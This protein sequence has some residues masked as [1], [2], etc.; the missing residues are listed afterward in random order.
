MPDTIFATSQKSPEREKQK[1]SRTKLID[2]ES[3]FSARALQ[4]LVKD[5]SDLVVDFD[6]RDN[7]PRKKLCT[8]EDLRMSIMT[9]SVFIDSRSLEKWSLMATSLLLPSR[10]LKTAALSEE[11]M[12]QTILQKFP[13]SS[14]FLDEGLIEDGGFGGDDSFY[15]AENSSVGNFGEK[16]TAKEISATTDEILNDIHVRTRMKS[17][18]TFDELLGSYKT[19]R[20]AAQCFFSVL[21]LKTHQRICV[22]QEKSFGIIT[23]AA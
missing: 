1:R 3:V 4:A 18:I 23:L 15:V 16:L 6:D 21:E 10:K 5:A 22:R 11:Q 7:Q 17:E 12:P 2:D 13:I 20:A 19:R 8:V 9:T 14:N